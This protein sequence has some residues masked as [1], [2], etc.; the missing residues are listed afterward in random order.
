MKPARLWAAIAALAAAPAAAADFNALG[1]LAQGELRALATDLGAAFSYKAVSPAAPLGLVGFDVGVE[2]ASTSLENSAAFALAGAGRPSEV[3]I[4]KLRVV[5]GLWGGFDIGAFVGGAATKIDAT[6][7]GAELR[8]ALLDDGLA[9][10]A[11]GLRLSGTRV[12]GTGD[13]QLATA[14]FDVSISKRFA[15]LTPYAGGGVVR[16]HGEARGTGLAEERFN[17][18]R[19]FAGLSVN[20]LAGDLALEAERMG[21][22]TTLSARLGF[23]F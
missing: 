10:P 3:V 2:V 16:V 17:K 21:D 20:L 19:A 8:Y 11:V 22:N 5:K 13:L 1:N 12:T 9:T 23:R 7:Y 6:L 4:P 18:G 14:A 15:L